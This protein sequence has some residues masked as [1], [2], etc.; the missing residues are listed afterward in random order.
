MAVVLP[1][2]WRVDEVWLRLLEQLV[3]QL[4]WRVRTQRALLS[5]ASPATVSL[6]LRPHIGSSAS[7]HVHEGLLE[8]ACPKALA[9]DVGAEYDEV[10]GPGAIS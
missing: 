5:G 1:F 6:C 3:G 4:S 8:H 9:G 7:G 10:V 2:V